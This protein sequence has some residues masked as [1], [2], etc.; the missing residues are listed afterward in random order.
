M[1]IMN[2]EQFLQNVI[3]IQQ[4]KKTCHIL[5]SSDI[6]SKLFLLEKVLSKE[7][8]TLKQF[9]SIDTHAHA[10]TLFIY[11]RKISTSL[12]LS[13]SLYI[14]IYIYACVFVCA[15]RKNTGF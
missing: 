10:H 9:S 8:D 2:F 12:S 3:H 7:T 11:P 4:Q 1:N 15:L 5:N 6:F 13:L 14:Y